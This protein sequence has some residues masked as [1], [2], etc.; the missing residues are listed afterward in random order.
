MQQLGNVFAS[1]ASYQIE[2]KDNWFADVE[3]REAC[4]E[5]IKNNE[6]ILPRHGASIDE[7][8]FTRDAGLT[9]ILRIARWNV[10]ETD[11]ELGFNHY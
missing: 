10:I 8:H 1:L 5:A 2:R 4:L 7:Y 6:S 3:F 9:R 11:I